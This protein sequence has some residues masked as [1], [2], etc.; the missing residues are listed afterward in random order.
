[1][2]A[3]IRR[4]VGAVADTEALMRS[5]RSLTAEMSHVPGFVSHVA[6]IADDGALVS[7]SIC[8]DTT[9]LET[10]ARLLTGWLSV[11]LPEAR[12]QPDV[13]TGQIIMQRG[14]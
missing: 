6:F 13:L 3:M 12:Q 8:E 9:G 4:D 14:L 2:H 5:G 7:I 1:M 11:N 10:I